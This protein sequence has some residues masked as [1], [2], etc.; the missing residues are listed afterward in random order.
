MVSATAARARSDLPDAAR[1]RE[2][3]PC[4]G[5][6]SNAA[7][8]MSDYRMPGLNGAEFLRM[9][10]RLQEAVR[11]VLSASA[12]FAEVS[13]AINQAEE[14]GITRVDRD[15]DGAVYLDLDQAPGLQRANDSRK[16]G[17]QAYTGSAPPDGGHATFPEG[18]CH[19][20][21][22]W[23][24]LPYSEWKDTLATLH[25]WTQVVGKVRLARSAPL[26]H[27]WQAAL[28]VTSRGLTT[29]PIPFGERTFEIA[30]DFIAHTLEVRAS[31]GAMRTLALR[32][33]SVADFYLTLLSELK[34]MGLPVHIHASPNEVP[35][36]IP[37]EEDEMHASYDPEY[38]N[39]FWRALVQADR[40]L[41]Q[42]RAGFIGKAS[43]VHFFWGSF[44]LAATRFSGAEAPP[45]PGGVPNCPDWVTRDAYSHEVS[46][47]GFWP[48]NDALPYALFYAYAYPEPPGFRDAPV[49]PPGALYEANF[50]EF[51]LPYDVVR[52]AEWP[53]AVLLDF[54]Q[55]AYDAAADLGK[56]N[57]AA[58]E[59]RVPVEAGQVHGS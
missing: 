44:D 43:P 19:M 5:S 2:G 15:D 34:S 45:H 22:A 11:L 48:G 57:R 58:L 47:C 7:A 52:G 21:L 40:V 3:P 35:Q 54:V 39:R 9:V 26:N 25:M 51:I 8:V 28:Y 49:R 6:N 53:D 24:A 37:F 12:D 23:P 14:P 13:N 59:R 36:A 4:R 30:F 50:G 17:P 32:P 20:N 55:S 31:D 38:A 46:S 16:A 10:K 41:K 29:S 56:W 27:S 33:R 1:R 18:G 42:F